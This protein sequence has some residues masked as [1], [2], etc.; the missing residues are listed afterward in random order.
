MNEIKET[1]KQFIGKKIY[2]RGDLDFNYVIDGTP[3]YRLVV[4]VGNEIV[5]DE[6]RDN[7]KKITRRVVNDLIDYALTTKRL[8][9]RV[10]TY[11]L[12]VYNG[13]FY[14]DKR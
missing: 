5:Y 14:I 6:G 11:N 8:E 9:R 10:N 1:I 7:V 2:I 3:Q 12:Y 13:W 4:Q